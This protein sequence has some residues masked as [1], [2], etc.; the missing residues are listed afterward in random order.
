MRSSL[1]GIRAFANTTGITG[2]ARSFKLNA[3]PNRKVHF[4]HRNYRR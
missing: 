2:T 3:L 1:W 4:E